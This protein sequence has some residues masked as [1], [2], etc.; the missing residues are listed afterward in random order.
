MR[1][2]DPSG[3]SPAGPCS[4]GDDCDTDQNSDIGT[5]EEGCGG[6]GCDLGGN[7]DGN[8]RSDK[9]NTD[10]ESDKYL[11][12]P[13]KLW[14]DDFFYQACPA[15]ATSCVSQLLKYFALTFGLPV[16][17]PL[18]GT[19]VGWHMT[20]TL[21]QYGHWYFGTGGDLGKNVLG[22]SLSLVEGRFT[23]DQLPNNDFREMMAL[24]KFLTGFSDQG[25]I[26]PFLY[27]GVNYSSST[28]RTSFEMG[29][30]SFQAGWS[31]TF[32]FKIP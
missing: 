2:T 30:G 21:D 25:Y 10:N 19:F 15:G 18:T 1:Y 7:S 24:E 14:E 20:L 12:N 3:H 31:H 16:T 26:V 27:V 4:P 6:Q 8:D 5:D 28:D 22:F 32:N 23:S 17:N 13:E 9:K 29:I 11:Y